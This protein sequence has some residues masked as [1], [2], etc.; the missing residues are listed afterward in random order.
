MLRGENFIKI[1]KKQLFKRSVYTNLKHTKN[2]ARPYML[3]FDLY[4]PLKF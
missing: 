1:F 4:Q 2:I 3:P